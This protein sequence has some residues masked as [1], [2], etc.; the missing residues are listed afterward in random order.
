MLGCC[1]VGWMC[2]RAPGVL[3]RVRRRCVRGFAW[4]T[5]G[6]VGSAVVVTGGALAPTL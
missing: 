3:A 6:L 5:L 1:W 2:G 4:R